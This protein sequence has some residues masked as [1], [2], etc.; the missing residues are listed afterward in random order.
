MLHC[1]LNVSQLFLQPVEIRP[2]L[3][4]LL[5]FRLTYLSVRLTAALI[6]PSLL[7]LR[8]SVDQVS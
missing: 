1:L 4:S 2:R 5:Q 7:E 6:P 3:F 8:P